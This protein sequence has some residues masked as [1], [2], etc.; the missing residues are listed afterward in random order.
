MKIF[1]LVLVGLGLALGGPAL[2]CWEATEHGLA[3]TAE[4]L[5]P[6]SCPILTK[7]NC[8]TLDLWCILNCAREYVDATGKLHNAGVGGQPHRV[9]TD[10]PKWCKPAK[11]DLSGPRWCAVNV[12]H[13]GDLCG[14]LVCEANKDGPDGQLENMND[15][16]TANC[17]H[18]PKN[19]ICDGAKS[20]V[21]PEHNEAWCHLAPDGGDCESE[22]DT[23]CSDTNIC[24]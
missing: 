5:Q 20:I 4:P 23:Y 17:N 19:I 24:I 6:N 22:G 2:Q 12:G 3:S 10:D 8:E 11:C 9:C 1:A 21:D 18:N 16:C 7:G 15:W 13:K 14:R